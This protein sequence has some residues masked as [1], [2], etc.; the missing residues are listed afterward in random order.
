MELM[1]CP[2]FWEGRSGYAD[3]MGPRR[4]A[5]K[6]S[7]RL[8]PRLIIGRARPII[9]RNIVERT[10]LRRRRTG[11]FPDN[12]GNLQ[13]IYRDAPFDRVPAAHGSRRALRALLTMRC[14]RRALSGHKKPGG[15]CRPRRSGYPTC[16]L[17]NRSRA[18]PRSARNS[19]CG[20]SPIPSWTGRQKTTCQES[21]DF[22]PTQSANAHFS[23]EWIR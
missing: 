8:F 7:P 17:K 20:F 3:H 14:S 11:G 6:R 13:A 10:G 22:L 2:D 18:G 23:A 5:G 21:F 12:T 9:R 19:N 16:A 4:S 1:G 15:R